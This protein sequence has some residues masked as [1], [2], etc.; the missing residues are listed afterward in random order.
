MHVKKKK[1]KTDESK[2]RKST[3]FQTVIFII[4]VHVV[5][6]QFQVDITKTILR[7]ILILLFASYKPVASS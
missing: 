2:C 1:K 4:S 5:A 6:L 7:G 3:A